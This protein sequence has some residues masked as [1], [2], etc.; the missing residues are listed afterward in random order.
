MSRPAALPIE[1]WKRHTVSGD[2]TGSYSWSGRARWA[3]RGS[4][5]SA[6]MSDSKPAARR[7]CWMASDS[8]PMASP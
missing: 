6:K 3:M 7:C 4:T 2:E 5:C 8:L 1:K